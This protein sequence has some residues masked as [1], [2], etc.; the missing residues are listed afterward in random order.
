MSEL[1]LQVGEGVDAQERFVTLMAGL[2]RIRR[3]LESEGKWPPVDRASLGGTQPHA[4][5]GTPAPGTGPRPA[6][7]ECGD[8]AVSPPQ[9]P[10]GA[11]SG[12]VA[13]RAGEAA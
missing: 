9:D 12:P 6:A 7:R 2:Y 13:S 4:V 10:R 3:R 11:A 1:Q 8:R 5:V